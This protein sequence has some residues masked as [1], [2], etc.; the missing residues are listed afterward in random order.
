[1]HL[2]PP[3]SVLFFSCMLFI[4]LFICISGCISDF[5]VP[6]VDEQTLVVPSNDEVEALQMSPY[7]T[8][9]ATYPNQ[10]SFPLTPIS[11]I[12]PI[13]TP[14]ISLTDPSLL[15]IS[16][17]YTI[18]SEHMK[19]NP[20]RLLLEVDVANTAKLDAKNVQL[21]YE[22]RYNRNVVGHAIIYCGIIAA[23]DVRSR[24]KTVFISLSANDFVKFQENPSGLTMHLVDIRVG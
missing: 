11:S 22:F 7:P 15:A 9:I 12:T 23:Q 5:S 4:F 1:M 6:L 20:L 8:L 14:P 3:R 2:Y 16:G 10:L 21:E 18:S 19:M 17:L 24:E 13:P